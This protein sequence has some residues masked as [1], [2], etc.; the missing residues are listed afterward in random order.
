MGQGID[1][2][3]LI[4]SAA[5]MAVLA[6]IVLGRLEDI[7]EASRRRV[8]VRDSRQGTAERRSP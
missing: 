4:V 2:I 8:Y 1:A 3:G 6:G 5:A 7:L